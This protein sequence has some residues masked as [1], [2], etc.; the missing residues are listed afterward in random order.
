MYSELYIYCARLCI[1]EY[2][3]SINTTIQFVYAV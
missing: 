2:F 3:Y 1:K